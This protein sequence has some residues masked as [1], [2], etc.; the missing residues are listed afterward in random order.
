ME[1]E[2]K[3]CLKLVNSHMSLS[4]CVDLWETFKAMFP[5]SAIVSNFTLGKDKASYIV[6]YGLALYFKD[7]LLQRLEGQLFSISFDEAFNSVSKRNQCDVHIAYFH[8]DRVFHQYFGSS[9]LGHSTANEIKESIAGILSGLDIRRNLVHLGMDG[10]NVNF[11]VQ[12]EIEILKGEDNPQLLEIGSCVL[13]VLHG[14]YKAG[15]NSTT[16]HVK[17]L[18]QSAHNLFKNSPAKR[19]DFLHAT[20][21][22]DCASS[23]PK[24]FCSHRWLENGP[25]IERML[26]IQDKIRLY[27]QSEHQKPVSKRSKSENFKFIESMVDS[28]SSFNKCCAQ[29]NFSLF[30]C[31]ILEPFLLKFQAERPLGV[32]LYEEL[33]SLLETVLRTFVK[34]TVLSD[35]S[36]S[37]RCFI[38]VG[39]VQ[40]LKPSEKVDIGVGAKTKSKLLLPSEQIQFRSDCRSFLVSFT[41]KCW[42][43]VH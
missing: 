42:S 34:E 30:V 38:D 8:N 33:I 26:S 11:A 2:I 29:L 43:E 12:R 41:K 13:H 35:T 7:C 24:K 10:P 31:N 1:S 25:A 36:G 18:L 19:H 37:R 32:F 5:D 6:S 14:A 28:D 3:W 4:S 27:V 9:F 15:Q 16:W 20:Q 23:F 21:S 17:R 22:K 39:N 40:N